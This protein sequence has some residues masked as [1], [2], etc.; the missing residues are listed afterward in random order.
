MSI[1]I[2]AQVDNSLLKLAGQQ[3]AFITSAALNRTA[4]GAR[5][6]V[7]D[8]LPKRFALRNGWTR[9]GVQART[10]NKTSLTVS[11]LAPGYMA[12]QETGGDRRPVEGRL[13]ASPSSRLQ[14][15]RLIPKSKRP[16]AL[17]D[18]KAF[19]VDMPDGDVGVF[20]R[21]GRKR[22]SIRLLWWLTPEQEYSDR[23][24]FERDV[25]DYVQDRFP[26]AFL[27]EWEKVIGQGGYANA[28]AR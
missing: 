3:S 22:K 4:I 13:L 12:L 6:R 10:G 1:R 11:V 24:E 17:L 27:R 7:R 26:S 28:R 23:F 19:F 2:L 14:S 5:D 21:Y 15:S 18:G 16:R 8:N 20:M 25:N 9:G